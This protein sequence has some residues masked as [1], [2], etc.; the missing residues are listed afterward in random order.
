MRHCGPRKI[1]KTAGKKY[2][3]KQ[4]VFNIW[5]IN[6]NIRVIYG[7]ICALR[8]YGTQNCN[9]AVIITRRKGSIIGIYIRYV[10]KHK[11]TEQ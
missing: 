3:I 4:H 7:L 2:K 10:Y 5:T 6:L 11:T 1:V 9:I 8:V